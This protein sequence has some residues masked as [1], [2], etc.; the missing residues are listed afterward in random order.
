M[1]KKYKIGLTIIVAAGVVA[2]VTRDTPK[3]KE[4]KYLRKGNEFFE[5]GDNQKAR[6][7]YK[8]A[9]K[10]MPTD[11]EIAYRWGLVDEAEGDI[12]NA[13]GGFLSAEQQDHHY[14]LALQ[15]LAHYL[16]AG[17]QMDEAQKR[18]DVLL[19]DNPNN[20]E[21][22]AL[23]AAMYLQKKDYD[24]SEKEAHIALDKEPANITAISVLT[25]I[26]VN[27][28]DMAKA[29][30][31]LDN[32]IKLNP[33]NIPLLMLKAK[34][35]D[36]P[37]N[38]EKVKE[39]YKAIFEIKPADTQYR[40]YLAETY[41]NA[42][43]LNEAEETLHTAI[44]AI[45]G[46]WDL[47]HVLVNFLGQYRSVEVAEKEI[48]DLMQK[49]PDKTELSLWLA[50]LYVT[51]NNVDKAVAVLQQVSAKD[52]DDKSSL[53]AKTSLARINF[54]KGDKEMA[55]KIVTAVLKD[56]PA[57]RDALFIRANMEVERNQ[58]ENAVTDLR[59][60]IRDDPKNKDAHQLLSEVLLMQGH[61]DL[62]IDMMNQLIDIDPVDPAARTRLAQMYNLNKN[63]QKA[64]EQLSI[65][66]TKNPTYPVGWESTARIAIGM[67][68]FDLARSS[69]AKLNA[70]EGQQPLANYLEA[71]VAA[72]NK[73]GEEAAALY[74]KVIDVNP[75]SPLAEH[76]LRSLIDEHHSPEELEKTTD[77]IASLKTDS[78]F[79]GT[80]LGEC[81]LKLGKVDLA[82]TT[83]YQ[84]LINHPTS[85]DPYLDLANLLF[86]DKKGDEAIEL[87][88]KAAIAIPS[89]MRA[90][91]MEGTIL[92][93][94][95]NY[96][97][98]VAMYDDLLK[99][100]PGLTV[101]ANNMASI[102][103][104]HFYTD[105]AMLEKGRQAV[106]RFTNSKEPAMLDT[107]GWTYY[108]LNKLDLAQA[109]F[110]RAISTGNNVPAEIHYHYGAT[111]LKAGNKSQAKVEL[112]K[113][114]SNDAKGPD[115]DDAK[116]LLSTI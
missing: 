109:T 106:E 99:T 33:K 18:I 45:P 83:L 4:A 100:N 5:Q 47:K 86:R 59:S 101:A 65:V 6:L 102:I 60:I 115:I 56:H 19:K 111:L 52:S 42:K 72:A 78:P 95:Q 13:F 68:D 104:D 73:K 23:Q 79:V 22:H 21:A 82:T 67:K 12:R 30:E 89:D 74:K 3:Q 9:A 113:A 20:A 88:K 94:Q 51:H 76:A 110:A 39:A 17:D 40:F 112:T 26:Y 63:T 28:K 64:L 53:N 44:T 36:N 77:Y 2:F 48:K 75:S 25:G 69:I 71:Q 87:L 66:T 114:V 41:I 43:M 7:A 105:P 116:K 70:L 80:L 103:A 1:K 54:A 50:N 24:A 90:A 85:Q 34:I 8:N 38:V 93:S 16:I 27:N 58:Y 92:Y 96:K 29:G 108:R 81:Y 84:A 14:T 11:P 61:P 62:A 97:D 98:A 37:F 31:A 46:D 57:N 15:K 49:N 55:E 32:G 107:I 91:I 10:I 35:Y